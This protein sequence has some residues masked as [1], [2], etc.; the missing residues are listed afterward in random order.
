ML[1]L[2]FALAGYCASPLANERI[3]LVIGN[4][5]Y[6]WSPLANPRNDAESMAALLESAGF[7]VD[8]QLD[9]DL[10]SLRAAVDRFG[11]A[12]RAPEVKFGLFYY[13][14]HGVQQNWHNYLVPIDG[15]PRSGKEVPEKTVDI[16]SLIDYLEHAQGRNF[17]VILDACR[18]DPFAGTYVPDSKGLSQFDAPVGSLLA[19]ATG[20][21][22]VALD[23]DGSNGLYT[24]NL[25]RE[26]SVRDARLEEAFKRVRLNVRLAS[27]GRQIPWE[28]TSLEEEIY[29]FPSK[30]KLLTEAEIDQLMQRELR[31]WQRV[32]L[33]PDIAEL[34]NFIREYPSGY[35]SEL[36][37]SRL[38]RMLVAAYGGEPS[39]VRVPTSNATLVASRELA[40][41]ETAARE[42]A[43]QAEQQRLQAQRAEAERVQQ[44]QLEAARQEQL[45]VQAEKELADRNAA[46]RLAAQRARAAEE[47]TRRV[48]AARA[49]LERL[50]AQNARRE[51]EDRQR[52]AQAAAAQAELARVA[53]Q[54]QQEMMRLAS[55]RLASE[56]LALA[57][58]PKEPPATTLA[59]TPFF[60]GY[61]E[62]RREYTLGDQFR[63]NV[64]DGFKNTAQ[65]LVMKITQIDLAAERVVFND[66]A[67]E[68]DLMGNTT[69]NQLG[70]FS[71]PRQFYPAELIVGKKWRTRFK[72]SRPNGITYTFQY[73]LKVVGKERI[74]V[75]AG[76]FEAF[77]IEARGFNLELQASIERTIWVAP[78]VN[79]DIAQDYKVRLRTGTLNEYERR[80][81][82]SYVQAK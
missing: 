36:A 27:R 47:E 3:A 18:D 75:P 6:I 70:V 54:R 81:L 49:E 24:S 39:T 15:R 73:D 79:A 19:Y 77:R 32:R 68:S 2:A 66:G 16:S 21:G 7:R 69:A 64:I 1:A 61:A 5:A 8:K 65:P 35:A 22:T 45:R 17:L 23:G 74:T 52:A 55:E 40:E 48:A 58:A 28:S 4:S 13:A 9:T 63:I 71:T 43:Q 26:L 11:R 76:S 34:S 41:A 38:N 67:F 33:N 44:A 37:Q 14:G 30:K 59:P 62:H 46:L 31:D 82:V 80:E 20:P 78:G 57:S 42:K 72:Q 10:T 60:K 53:Q 50:Q 25:L 56:R 29:L 51:A 12:A